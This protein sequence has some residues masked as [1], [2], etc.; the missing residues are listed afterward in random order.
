VKGGRH[1]WA[2]VSFRSQRDAELAGSDEGIPSFSLPVLVHTENPHR[3][4][5][6]P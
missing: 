3:C 2:L 1:S 5:I 4:S 6:F